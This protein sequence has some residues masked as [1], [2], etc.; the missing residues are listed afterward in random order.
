ME[1]RVTGRVEDVSIEAGVQRV[2][3]VSGDSLNGITY[4][5]RTRLV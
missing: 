5:V 3:D 2:Y 4:S 1:K